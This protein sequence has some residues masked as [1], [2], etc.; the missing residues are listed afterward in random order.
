MKNSIKKV[1][2]MAMA[3]VMCLAIPLSASA[4]T[5][6]DAV[7]DPDAD[8]SLSIYKYDFTNA[9]KDGVWTRDAFT[10]TGVYESY[11]NTTLGGQDSS[12][13]NGQTANG[14][15]IKGVEFTYLKTADISTF[16]ESTDGVNTTAVLYGFDKAGSADLLAAIGLDSGANRYTAADS[17]DKLDSSKY[18]YTSDVLI[19]ALASA[20][21]ANSTA[22][23]NALETYIVANGGT[24]MPL[25]DSNGYT[26]ASN[27][28]VGLYLLVETAVPEMVTSTVNPFFVSL[29]MTTV[30]GNE[31]S[32]SH[33]GGQ[34]WNYHVTVY[35][36]N[37]TGIPTLEK[38]V[39]EAVADTGK[40][41]GSNV[42]TDGYAHNATGSAGDVMEYQ[43]IST[44][45][46]ITSQATALTTYQ[47]YDS[48]SDGLEY[49]KS[50]GVKVEFFTDDACTNRVATWD[51]SSGKF[52]VSY[53]DDDRHMTVDVTAS[54]LAEINGN[55][56]N[57]NGALY[58]GYSNYTV[59]VT[60]SAVISSDASFVC[61]D[62]GNDNK[63]VL[64]WKRSSQDYY[65]TLIDDCHVYS[66][67]V[68][69]TKVFS[70]MT[71]AA[72][73]NEAL[74]QAV[75][76]KIY[77]E[78]DGY[79][80][81]AT[82]NDAEGIYYVT[83]HVGAEADATVFYPVTSGSKPGKIIVKGMEDDAYVITEIET[84]NGY[85]L[86]KD[87]IRVNIHT[88]DNKANPCDIYS[89]DVLGVLQNDPYYA[90][91]GG[92]DLKL[93]NIP[94]KALAHNMLTASATV[95]KND[96]SMHADNDSPNA[97]APMTVVNTRGFDLPQTGETGN[98]MY[99]V[100]G[101]I[102]MVAAGVAFF[103]ILRKKD[104]KSA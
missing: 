47:F 87:S 63:V 68:D 37:L 64:T 18:Y 54:G 25:T 67:G 5:T 41:N 48:L 51:A 99:G 33:N 53:S 90:Y 70:D 50:A 103:L 26:T 2:A 71:S 91:N 58:A 57:E 100:F 55:T 46:T 16:T 10:S 96:V 31:Q 82:R 13:G 83:G 72:A 12:L 95:D 23:K 8:C 11:V 30:D 73:D 104:E 93:A 79:W 74:F 92:L 32:A 97:L 75:K 52:S 76:F 14:Y 22:V 44:L 81:T 19:K 6:S 102:A 36:K 24:A 42:I 94:Q 38:T 59:R 78:T 77:N 28:P 61:G 43:F 20:L 45:P 65:D 17:S 85:T 35:P 15:A 98:W 84:A 34:E 39:R 21:E 9:A 69:L 88:E 40:N 62:K 60:Y 29:P 27:L 66:F 86:L 1:L 56:A 3:I 4:A 80:L 7:I 89:E 101:V 49:S